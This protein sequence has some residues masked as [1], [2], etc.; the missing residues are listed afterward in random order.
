MK[1]QHNSQLNPR[2]FLINIMA[3]LLKILL[4]K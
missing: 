2:I 1:M 3:R 4:Y